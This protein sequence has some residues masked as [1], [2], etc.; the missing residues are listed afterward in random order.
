MRQID[1][2]ALADRTRVAAETAASV[3]A[4]HVVDIIFV[5]RGGS[6]SAKEAVA[7]VT[8]KLK[9][10]AHNIRVHKQ[11]LNNL[12]EPGEGAKATAS[13]QAQLRE[14]GVAEEKRVAKRRREDEETALVLADLQAQLEASEERADNAEA[15]AD[16][17]KTDTRK[18]SNALQ[19]SLARAEERFRAIQAAKE[20]AAGP[21]SG[22]ITYTEDEAEEMEL[23]IGELTKELS[24]LRKVRRHDEVEYERNR[25]AVAQFRSKYSEL[26]DLRQTR[27]KLQAQVEALEKQ[28]ETERAERG[29]GLPLLPGAT[30]K[31]PLFEMARDKSKH[32]AP[33]PRY[34]EDVIAIAMLDTGATPEQI[35][36]I[37]RE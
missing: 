5:E 35:N 20:T 15:K 12:I 37:I 9:G 30:Y 22:A 36:S 11:R 16:A 6:A 34:F 13:L 21:S 32:G 23:V 31:V 19:H 27:N 28:L 33:Y 3:A 25:S 1:P 4:G 18:K 17:L 24:E 14:H 7:K 26:A 8:R 2:S 10:K 29:P